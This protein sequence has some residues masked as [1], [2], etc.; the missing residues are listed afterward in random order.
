MSASFTNQVIAQI[1]LWRHHATYQRQVY[2]LPKHLDEKVA[3]LHLAK[4][5]AKLT[6]LSAEQA[7]YI[8]VAGTGPFKPDTYRY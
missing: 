8:G 1:E 5:G 2:V 3:S 6:R 7:A 4:L